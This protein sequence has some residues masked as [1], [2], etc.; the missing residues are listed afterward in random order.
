MKQTGLFVSLNIFRNRFCSNTCTCKNNTFFLPSITI[1]TMILNQFDFHLSLHSTFYSSN[2]SNMFLFSIC[3]IL[4]FCC[5]IFNIFNTCWTIHGC[6][7]PT[8]ILKR[9]TVPPGGTI[10]AHILLYLILVIP[11]WTRNRIGRS[12]WTVM[13]QSAVVLSRCCGLLPWRT[14]VSRGAHAR[15]Y[16]IG[17]AFAVITGCAVVAPGQVGGTRYAGHGS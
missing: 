1:F 3:W 9:I 11:R 5:R 14:V 12:Q 7:H 16:G 10:L 15:F 13:A 2:T 4:F 6:N 8:S 17:G